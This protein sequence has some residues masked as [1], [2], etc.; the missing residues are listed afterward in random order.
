VE[1]V[2]VLSVISEW[3]VKAVGTSAVQK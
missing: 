3:W 1:E 2:C